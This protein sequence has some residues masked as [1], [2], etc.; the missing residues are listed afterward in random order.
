[1]R[2]KKRAYAEK[3][4]KMTSDG[5]YLVPVASVSKWSAPVELISD[6]KN[7]INT[8]PWK[9]NVKISVRNGYIPDWS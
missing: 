2:K 5:T 1:M 7:V 6:V 9:K 3:K 4:K 8:I